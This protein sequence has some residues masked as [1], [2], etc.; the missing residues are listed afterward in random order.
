ML[1]TKTVKKAGKYVNSKHVDSLLGN[2]KK[3]RWVQNSK[4]IGKEDSLSVWYSVEELQEFLETAKENGADGI[5]MYFGV[6]K[7][8]TAKEERYE[9]RQTI[10]LVASKNK[11]LENGATIDKS[12]YINGDKGAEILAYNT[13]RIC[14]PACAGTG[15]DTGFD[16]DNMG[17]LIDRKDDGMIII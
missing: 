16:W 14:P 1:L 8:D 10:V 13:G 3:E 11:V 6:Y 2:Y 15:I 17:I 5:K 7:A 9:E 12:I 4:H